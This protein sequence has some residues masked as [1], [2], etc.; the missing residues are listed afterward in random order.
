M[1]KVDTS[2]VK[3]G[4]ILEI[5]G[6]L[7]RVVETAHTHM[8]RWGATDTYKLKDIVSWKTTIFTCNAGTILEQ[9]EVQ[10]M[11]AVFLY[12]AGDTYTFMENDTWEMYDL[13]REKIDD[14]VD[15][16]KEN[17]DVYLTVFKGEVLWV[18]LPTTVSYVITSTVPGVKWN[19]MQAGTKPATIETWLEVQVPL[20]K[21][22][23]DTVI[24]NTVTWEAS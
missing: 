11:A 15:Y 9:A 14:V 5:D 10:N 23:W 19:R 21:N 20:H 13:D 12:S 24:I 6:K 3:K 1:V 22:E 17:L 7:A 18:I 2:K 16:L 8:G 4:M